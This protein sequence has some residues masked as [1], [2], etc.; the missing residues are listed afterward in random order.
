MAMLTTEIFATPTVRMTTVLRGLADM[1]ALRQQRHQLAT[2]DTARLN[3]L[4][5][6]RQDA[7]REASRKPW[8]VPAHWR[9]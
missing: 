9:R 8:D 1:V 3:D 2:L 4:G 5:L 6:S 7:Q